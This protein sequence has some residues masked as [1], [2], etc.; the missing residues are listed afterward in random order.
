M[1]RLLLKILF[2]LSIRWTSFQSF[3]LFQPIC[4]ILR[5]RLYKAIFIIS[6]PSTHYGYDRKSTRNHSRCSNTCEPKVED[7]LVNLFVRNHSQQKR[8]CFEKL[9]FAANYV[10]P[11]R[12]KRSDIL[13]ILNNAEIGLDEAMLRKLERDD[14]Y[15][16][17]IRRNNPKMSFKDLALS[18]FITVDRVIL[19]V[20]N[21]QVGAGMS[22][23][24]ISG[25]YGTLS[26]IAEEKGSL[27]YNAVFLKHKPM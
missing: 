25:D 14:E 4:I 21:T 12:G 8:N 18:L 26:I 24:N 23:M 10:E 5:R 6:Y 1:S 17:E 13:T 11:I 22:G 3:P 19:P 7:L 27:S 2:Q 20:Y 16:L 9:V 15:R